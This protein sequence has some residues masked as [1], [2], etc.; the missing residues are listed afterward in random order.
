MENKARH[1]RCTSEENTK[2]LPPKTLK[3]IWKWG[4]KA[5]IYNHSR[6]LKAVVKG[7]YAKDRSKRPGAFLHDKH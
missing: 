4:E 5:V 3:L 6:K 2:N 1:R 7:T